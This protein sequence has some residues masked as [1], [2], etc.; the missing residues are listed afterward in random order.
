MLGSLARWLRMI[1]YD[2]VY[3]K[4]MDDPELV[5]FARA[6]NRYLLTRDKELAKEPGSFL[7]EKDDLDAQLEA[8]AAKF[9]LHFAE[10]RIRCS[11]CNGEL[12]DLPK[13]LAKQDVPE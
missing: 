1:G 5:K 11:T 12:H 13:E 4:N 3:D 10:D 9:A 7:V 8:T 2:T 6:G